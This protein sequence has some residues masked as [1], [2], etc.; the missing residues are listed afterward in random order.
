MYR[1][2]GL[3]CAG[4]IFPSLTLNNASVVHTNNLLVLMMAG[5]SE[6]MA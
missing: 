4:E 2:I 6:L 1:A 5:T 3:M